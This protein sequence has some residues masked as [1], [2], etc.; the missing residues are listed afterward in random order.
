MNQFNLNFI[1]GRGMGLEVGHVKRL[2][3]GLVLRLAAQGNTH[4][5]VVSRKTTP[6]L[7]KR[8]GT[9]QSET[10]HDTCL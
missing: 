6:H 5:L 1:P 2:V 9:I 3:E 8:P 4:T 10:V 7:F